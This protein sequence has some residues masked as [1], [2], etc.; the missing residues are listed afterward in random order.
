MYSRNAGDEIR[1]RGL[2]VFAHHGVYPEE[3]RD[4]QNFFIDAVLTADT[5]K[6]GRT[7]ALEDSTNYGEVCH[8]IT[9]WMQQN[10]RKLIEAVAEG[11]AE[12]L[13]LR[14]PL[15]SAVE[16]EVKK[17]E[18]PIGL[19]FEFVSVRVKRSWHRA[20][21]AF[22]SNMGEREKYIEGAIE[23]L[24]GHPLIQ[25]K[26]VSETIETKPYGGVE[27]DDFLNGVLL[28][29]TLL[30][31][32]DLLEVLHEIENEAERKRTIHWGPRTLDLDILLFDRL[33]YESDDLII[34]HADMENRE[35]VLAPLASIAPNERHPI[36][37]RTVQQMLEELKQR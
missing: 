35:F 4:G 13:L 2:K 29:E 5:K 22:G 27:Q 8:F 32:E 24:K 15:L 28:L 26:E 36:L 1:I 33:V 3:T 11:L 34:P 21:I 19:P 30:E 25:V 31:P 12:A 20:Y 10:T 23:A 17:P 7:D 6:P 9:E 37:N 16:I 14:Y 18:A